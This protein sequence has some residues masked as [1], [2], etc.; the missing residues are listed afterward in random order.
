M[1]ESVRRQAGDAIGKRRRELGL[2]LA[3]VA[4][5]MGVSDGYIWKLEKGLVNLGNVAYGRLLALMRALRWTPEEFTQATGV[6]V[7]GLTTE[8]MPGIPPV[9]LLKV[10][11]KG[12]GEYLVLGLPGLEVDPRDL[13]ALAHRGGFVVYREEEEPEPGELAV[14]EPKE[15]DA[16]LSPVRFLGL[17]SRRSYVVETLGCPTERRTL[18]KGDWMLHRVV[19][20]VRVWG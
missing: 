2:T 13:R 20:E 15:G 6:A 7:P 3:D 8:E 10:P 1:V 14:A 18:E 9:P 16:P 4:R 12:S 17:N 19:G 11:L 5:E